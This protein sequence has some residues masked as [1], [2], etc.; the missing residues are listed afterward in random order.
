MKRKLYLD[1]IVFIAIL[2]GFGVLFFLQQQAPATET[3]TQEVVE[4]SAMGC[5]GASTVEGET[6]SETAGGCCGTSKSDASQSVD[7]SQQVQ[8]SGTP[9]KNE[10]DS[11]TPQSEDADEGGCGCGG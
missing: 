8:P 10:T 11:P 1:I 3:Q 5:C 7:N 9:E 2:S 4:A 6:S